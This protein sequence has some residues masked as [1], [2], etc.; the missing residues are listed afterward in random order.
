VYDSSLSEYGVLGFEY[1]YSVADPSTLTLWEAQFGD[2]SN[3][4]QI[5]IDQFL[6]TAEQKWSQVSG[7]TMLLPHGYE[8]QGP[9]HSSARIERFLTLSA[10][11]NIRVANCTTP[12][13]Y[14]HILRRQ[15]A[16][17]L[18][19]LILFTPKS[20]LRS[21]RATSRFSE[22]T[23]GE[24][25]E[26]IGDSL[27][28]ALVSR[29]V[30]CSGKVYYDLLAEREAKKTENIALV[31]LEQLY[32][33]PTDQIDEILARYKS[34]VELIWAQEEPRNMG[35]WRFIGGRFRLL[36]RNVRYVGRS[37]SAS[38]ATGSSKRHVAEQTRLV[39]E[40]IGNNA[41]VLHADT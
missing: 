10:E 8:G 37:S 38:P 3:G 39:R 9:E 11:D 36:G 2:F 16:V 40:A 7:L 30:F 18:K 23:S 4:A 25:R 17:P 41:G 13:Q 33:F 22:L 27:D 20:L 14:F 21:P 32:P 24:F 26:A 29:I 28:P 34:D 31:R 12:A 6:T 5:I 35:A 19:P 15:L 1:G